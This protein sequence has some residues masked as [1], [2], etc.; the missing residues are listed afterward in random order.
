LVLNPLTPGVAVNSFNASFTL[1]IGG[2]TAEPA[3]G[4]S[5]N[6]A[7]NVPDNPAY[8]DSED[9]MGTGFSFGVDNYRYFPL[10]VGGAYNAAGGGTQSTSGL[11]IAYNGIIL[12]GMQTP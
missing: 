7:N 9:G 3:D 8:T 6:F 5:F 4:F 12:G 2:G 10:N 11:K 1:R